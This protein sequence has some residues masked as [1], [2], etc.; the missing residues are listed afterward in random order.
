MEKKIFVVMFDKTPFPEKLQNYSKRE[1]YSNFAD[2][3]DILNKRVNDFANQ[4][5]SKISKT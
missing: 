3:N 2:I 5:D 4:I 1:Q